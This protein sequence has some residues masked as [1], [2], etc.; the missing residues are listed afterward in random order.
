MEG[1]AQGFEPFS[2]TKVEKRKKGCHGSSQEE[3]F[4]YSQSERGRNSPFQV[5]VLAHN[6][7]SERVRVRRT[8]R[9]GR[10]GSISRE[11]SVMSSIHIEKRFLYHAVI[12][13]PR[14]LAEASETRYNP[15]IPRYPVKRME[16]ERKERRQQEV[17]RR[18]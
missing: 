14:A 4:L 5:G 17:R 1:M 7:K 15:R 2:R 3:A 16:M 18:S 12:E 6:K 10:R 9:S 8:R 11:V 13:S